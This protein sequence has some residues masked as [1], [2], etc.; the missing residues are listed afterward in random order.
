MQGR[1]EA[2]TADNRPT[3]FY[4]LSRVNIGARKGQMLPLETR[5]AHDGRNSSIFF[6][7]KNA[8]FFSN[9]TVYR[10]ILEKNT[11]IKSCREEL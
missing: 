3:G 6:Y 5:A 10:M 2:P 1:A 11:F 4:L 7:C 8:N 9:N